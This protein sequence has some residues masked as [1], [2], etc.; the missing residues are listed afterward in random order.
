VRQGVHDVVDADANAERGILLFSF[1]ADK[2]RAVYETLT[3]TY[4]ETVTAAR[5][6]LSYHTH[7]TLTPEYEEL[8]KDLEM[9]R[10]ECAKARAALREHRERRR[11]QAAG[12]SK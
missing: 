4:T 7:N 6:A 10:A 2:G 5:H 8:Q 12:N 9:A 3:A 1:L 11:G